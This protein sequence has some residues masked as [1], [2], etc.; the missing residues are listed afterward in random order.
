MK[1]V[2]IIGLIVVSGLSIPAFAKGTTAAKP[3]AA[4]TH[5]REMA[6]EI[7]S[8]NESGKSLVLKSGGKN[9]TVYWTDATKVTGGSV[10]AG[11]HAVIRSMVKNGK[12]WATSVKI[13]GNGSMRPAARP[14]APKAP[15]AKK[16]S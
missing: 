10:K 15:A 2:A 12:T 5:G 6:G 4:A 9:T 7:V 13:V 3:A 1:R 14:A 8:V 11:E 16:S